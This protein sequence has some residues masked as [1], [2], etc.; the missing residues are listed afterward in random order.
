MI[1]D[2]LILKNF[3]FLLNIFIF[4]IFHS[5]FWIIVKVI[6]VF[7]SDLLEEL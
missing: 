1:V 2:F 4:L 7:Y 6:V 3:F 5:K